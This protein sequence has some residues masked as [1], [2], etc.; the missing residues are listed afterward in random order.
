MG[1]ESGKF[2]N[3]T[4]K[5]GVNAGFSG[6]SERTERDS[7]LECWVGERKKR[8]FFHRRKVLFNCRTSWGR[9]K[10][11]AE[12]R[13]SMIWGSSSVQEGGSSAPLRTLILAQSTLQSGEETATEKCVQMSEFCLDL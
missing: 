1:L 9:R 8:A 3:R 7:Q 11:A 4:E 13:D 6:D 5:L 10:L 12:E 2:P